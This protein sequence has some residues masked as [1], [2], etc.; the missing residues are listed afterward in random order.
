MVFA[1]VS[2][3]GVPP[4]PADA[5]SDGICDVAD[6]N[7]LGIAN[8]SQADPDQDGYG[9]ACDADINNNC[10]VGADD[11]SAIFSNL[12]LT[13]PW[14]P[15]SNGAMDLNANGVVGSDDAFAAFGLL[16]S[17]PGPSALS[18]ASCPG[19]VPGDCT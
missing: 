14:T 18:C 5:D 7:C 2:G 8:P 15:L 17:Q 12:F 4:C 9:T 13:A 3:A 16:F 1:L 11:V 6:D 10:V 19:T